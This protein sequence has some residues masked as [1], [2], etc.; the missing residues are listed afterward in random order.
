MGIILQLS[1]RDNDGWGMMNLV[2]EAMVR[3]S[4][5]NLR[6]FTHYITGSYPSRDLKQDII[7]FITYKNKKY[8]KNYLFNILMIYHRMMSSS[9]INIPSYSM[10]ITLCIQHFNN[11]DFSVQ[12]GI[13]YICIQRKVSNL[14][15][16]LS[17]FFYDPV[18][19]IK[20]SNSN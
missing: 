15:A 6:I 3:I 1:K 12:C 16:M 11:L 7:Y 10:L 19:K 18:V 2:N 17:M 20:D 9:K 13:I 14:E 5:F 4:D 8:H